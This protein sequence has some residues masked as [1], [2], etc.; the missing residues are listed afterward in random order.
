MKAMELVTKS[1]PVLN[2]N[3]S[4]ADALHLMSEYHVH[5]LAVVAENKLLGVISE[6]DILS[7]SGLD[8]PVGNLPITFKGPYLLEGEHAFEVLKLITQFNLTVIPVVDTENFYSGSILR[9]ELLTFLAEETD[10]LEPG[11]ILVLEMNLNDYSLGEIARILESAN[12]K[13]LAAFTKTQADANKIELT[14]KINQTQ[15]QPS[16][17]ALHRY[18]YT[19][20]ET[21]VEPEYFDGLKE[22]YDALM[23]YLDI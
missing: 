23:N 17:A 12:A 16:L 15:L 4:G 8:E 19:V 5:H 9:H 22:R 14:I 20:K 13:I 2:S 18:N 10:M 11:G 6:E 3:N 1:F 7:A 21:Y